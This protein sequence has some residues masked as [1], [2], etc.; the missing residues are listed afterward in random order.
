M[1]A[2]E[3]QFGGNHY[4]RMDVTPWNV[5]D[6]WPA[7]QRIGAYRFGILKYTMRLGNKDEQL[8]EAEKGLH[9][10]MKLVEVLRELA[11]K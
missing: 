10:A 9:Y 1:Q 2:D 7:E 5:V 11:S 6:T 8:Q 3:M 4:T